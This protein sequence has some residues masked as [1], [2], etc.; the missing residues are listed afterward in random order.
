MVWK[1]GEIISKKPDAGLI[2]FDL[3]DS[4]FC[5]DCEVVENISA[6]LNGS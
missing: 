4:R 3:N 2:T 1:L 5:A 6:Y